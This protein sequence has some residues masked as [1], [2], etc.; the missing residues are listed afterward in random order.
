MEEVNITE[1]NAKTW[2]FDDLDDLYYEDNNT[3]NSSDSCCEWGDVCDLDDSKDFE[4][5]FIPILYSVVFVVGFLGNG[6][7]LGVLLKSKRSWSVT[8]TFIFHLGV[9]DVLLLLTLPLWAAQA[10]QDDGWT[11]GIPLCK[12]TGAVFTV[13]I[14]HQE[15]TSIIQRSM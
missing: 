9:A 1:S 11:F 12:I 6:A 10:A 5:V 15:D 14:V 3:F 2:W 8:D 4:A 7:L 13:S